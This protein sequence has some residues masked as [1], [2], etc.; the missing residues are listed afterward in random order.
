MHFLFFSELGSKNYC[1][2]FINVQVEEV[3]KICIQVV[4]GHCAYTYDSYVNAV[5]SPMICKCMLNI[6]AWSIWFRWVFSNVNAQHVNALHMWVLSIR[7]Q[8]IHVCWAYVYKL[9]VYAEHSCIFEEME[10]QSEKKYFEKILFVT[11]VPHSE[12]VKKM[13]CWGTFNPNNSWVF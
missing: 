13:P 9:Y 8:F 7:L 11:E 6:N 4:P 12:I 1:P 5:H 2:R 10:Y 3:K